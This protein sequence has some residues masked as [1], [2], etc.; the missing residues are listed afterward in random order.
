MYFNYTVTAT[1]ISI[2]RVVAMV[3]V[4]AVAV[5]RGVLSVGRTELWRRS[6]VHYDVMTLDRGSAKCFAL[7]YQY[8]STAH[9]SLAA[10]RNFSAKNRK[11]QEER[12]R[13]RLAVGGA[14]TEAEA[15]VDDMTEASDSSDPS[16]EKMLEEIADWNQ[17]QKQVLFIVNAHMNDPQSSFPRQL[18]Q[19]CRPLLQ[20]SC[21]KLHLEIPKETLP[22]G[23]PPKLAS[24]ILEK[25]HLSGQGLPWINMYIWHMA[26]E[27]DE[28]PFSE[29]ERS[30]RW[31]GYLRRA[32][33]EQR[34][35]QGNL[36]LG[37]VVEIDSDIM[38]ATG[39][40]VG[41]AAN[42]KFRTSFSNCP[43]HFRNLKLQLGTTH[44]AL[45][46]NDLSVLLDAQFMQSP[47][48]AN[49]GKPLRFVGYEQSEF[50]IA[51]YLVVAD[52]FQSAENE[53]TEDAIFQVWYS[54][55]WSAETLNS[56]RVSCKRVLKERQ[57][58]GQQKA[59]LSNANTE[60]SQCI[61]DYLLHWLKSAPLSTLDA[62]RKWSKKMFSEG[63][64]AMVVKALSYTRKSDCIAL[65]R[66]YL[67][68]EIGVDCIANDGATTIKSDSNTAVVG[69]I[70]M[71]NDAPGFAPL[72]ATPESIMNTTL[73]E[74]LLDEYD[75]DESG[76]GDIIEYA[77]RIKL[78][79]IAR[80]KKL[81]S[82]GRITIDLRYGNLKPLTDATGSEL[83]NEISTLQ[84]DTMSWSN[85]MDYFQLHEVHDLARRWSDT[86]KD[87]IH[88]G[89]SMNWPATTYG[90][91][92]MDFDSL[93][94]RLHILDECYGKDAER[95][96][97]A[98]Q[99]QKLTIFA[100]FEDARGQTGYLQAAKL[101]D[102]WISHFEESA[103]SGEDN[104]SNKSQLE[105]IDTYFPLD[106]P[107]SRSFR[108][109]FLTWRYKSDAVILL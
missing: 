25:T 2:D 77:K 105:L 88:Y 68:G 71:W 16:N 22:A 79:Q 28:D 4:A 85:L 86:G 70:T 24:A 55:N 91:D 21:P 43:N 99:Q 58:L 96:F 47:D 98:S 54:S 42:Q 100:F 97:Q 73:L 65:T 101:K 46:F 81:V 37:D 15:A 72:E 109:L 83:V 1:T 11:R 66:Y 27:K 32:L 104:Q 107:A 19:L 26:H 31:H 9:R 102:D 18:M 59:D 17:K 13:K 23:V 45:G 80:L 106:N 40:P 35:Q 14:T 50:S 53:A 87:T 89:Y 92:I 3:V 36:Q 7:G 10:V 49:Y 39:T 95:A 29:K 103:C 41:Y 76:E 56:F 69:N 51:K 90:C 75:K 38:H 34:L 93:D 74:S 12:R 44:V 62:R 67:T 78:R 61:T 82:T 6:K 60:Q 8:Q 48:S 30:T 64:A 52:M 63:E 84:A 57:N 33:V 94:D 108:T 5:L 20:R